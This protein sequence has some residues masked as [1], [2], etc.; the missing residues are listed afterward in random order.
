MNSMTVEQL[1]QMLKVKE[2]IQVLD[3]RE[4]A[5]VEAGHIPGMVNMPLS[6]LEFRMNEL[7]KNTAYAVICHAGGRSAQATMF[8]QSHGYNVTNVE[9]GMSAWMGDVE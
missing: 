9:G 4:V 1:E 2:D 8:L 3:V 6:L 5:E 7:S